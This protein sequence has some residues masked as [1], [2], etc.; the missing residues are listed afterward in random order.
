M[1]W[2]ALRPAVTTGLEGKTINQKRIL[3]SG[4]KHM[5]EQTHGD[6]AVTQLLISKECYRVSSSWDVSCFRSIAQLKITCERSAADIKTK[7]YTYF[8]F[9]TGP[10][11]LTYL[12][13]KCVVPRTSMHSV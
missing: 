2:H 7:A 4:A 8:G 1:P 6:L 3:K 9:P 10:E 12:E 5:T 13:L 11:M